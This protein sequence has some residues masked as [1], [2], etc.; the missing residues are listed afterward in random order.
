MAGEEKRVH[1]YAEFARDVLPR[2]VR[3]GYNAIQLMAIQEHSYYASFGYLVNAFFAP[4]S[5]SGSPE[6]LRRLIDAAHEAGI[7]V[8]V[9]IVHSHASSNVDD[10]LNQYDGTDAGYF[11]AGGRG[12]HDLWNSRLFQ[13]RNRAVQRF[14]LSNLRYW[15]EE[16]RVDGFR[17]DGVTSML[18]LHHGIAVGF[19][20]N[21]DEYFRGAADDEALE[22]LTLA[23]LVC[24]LAQPP[25][26]TIAEDV[27]GMPTLCRPVSEG[28]LGFDYRLGMAIPDRWIAVLKEAR[29][30]EWDM[31]NLVF[32]LNNRRWNEKTVAYAESH[33]QALVGDKTLSF[34]LMDAAMYVGMSR[35][36]T[37][38]D[39]AVPLTIA[40][41]LALHKLI[42]LLTCGLGG[43][44]YLNFMGN[45][46]GH[47]EWID[48]PRE[49]NDWS[50]HYCRRQWSLADLDH[51]RYIDLGRFDAAMHRVQT[52][53]TALAPAIPWLSFRGSFVSRKHEG[54]KVVVFER[55]P[56]ADGVRSDTFEPV[57]LF[58]F[59]FHP[60]QSFVDYRVG[61]P[62]PG[63]WRIVLNSDAVAFGGFGRVDDSV[64]Y[65]SHAGEFDGRPAHLTLYLPN[66][67]GLVLARVA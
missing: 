10:G 48:F 52:D 50:Y 6:D 38:E 32:T 59:N 44:A 43:E 56:R 13:Y 24:H 30:E 47:P 60:T 58:A 35:L 25:A 11:H 46:F 63:R 14:L 61:A 33:D 36:V 2:V 17:F 31:G 57:A 15:I 42:R 54:D 21:Y 39:P 40:R 16:F 3:G 49:G 8:I 4:A 1:T 7:A 18:Y 41:G 55:F 37:P 26:L 27:S 5:R 53:A 62:C 51:L 28:G 19:S 34:R 64:V 67:T 65:E 45:E 20:G 29:D 22:Y 9:D 12:F 23:S 66:R